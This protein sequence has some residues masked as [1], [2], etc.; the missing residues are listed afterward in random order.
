MHRILFIID[1]PDWA[2]D[3]RAKIWRDMLLND[4]HIDLLYL[5]PLSS[6]SLSAKGYASFN[7]LL[8]I[9]ESEPASKRIERLELLEK[10]VNKN[11]GE[12]IQGEKVFDHSEYDGI[13]FFYSRAL[14]DRRLLGT[15]IPPHKVAVCINNEKWKELG[16]ARFFEDY[17][18][19]VEVIVG[20]NAHIIENFSRYHNCV[21]RAS[22]AVSTE[23][24]HRLPPHTPR[25]RGKDMV[26]GWSGNFENPLK[27]IEIVKEACEAAGV[28]LLISKNRNRKEL[29]LWY[30]NEIDLAVC[31]S[32]SE[33]GP[34]ILLEA[35]ACG[36]PI[37]STPVGLAR[38]I[39]VEGKNGL[40]FEH[41][42]KDQLVK[43]LKSLSQDIEL[44]DKMG[45]ELHKEV[46]ARWTYG[47]RLN[48][49][50]GVLERLCNKRL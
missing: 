23:V 14:H 32:S 26:V 40:L 1:V 15:V 2:Y 39:I 28:K 37:I 24:F 27:N 19:E 9:A 38:E 12:F 33:G 6:R 49:I 13:V 20:C 47:A 25:R 45:D 30:N 4:Y 43:L 21:M 44:R 46:I 10:W 34:M 36:K 41:G 17:L 8:G 48:E 22:Q 31:A 11:R 50:K 35:G 42:N 3:D 18:S 16:A 5:K 7:R 29:N